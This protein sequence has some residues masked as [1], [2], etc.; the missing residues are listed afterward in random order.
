ME[1]DFLHYIWKFKLFNQQGLTTTDGEKLDLLKVGVHNHDA[2]P[3]FFNGQIRLAGTR[4]AGN[5]ELHLKSSDWFRHQHQ[6]DKAYDKVILHVVWEADKVVKRKNG[7]LIPTL[8]LKG[9]VSKSKLEQYQNLTNGKDWVPCQS[10]LNNLDPSLK[11]LQVERM[12]VERLEVKSRRINQIL[13]LHQNDWEQ[14][15][16]HLLCKYF[17]FKVNATPFELLATSLPFKIIRKNQTDLFQI[18]ALL[19]G[20]AGLLNQD[21][22]G[23]YPKKL[24]AAYEFQRKK[25]QLK[26]MEGHLWKFSRMR[27]SNFPTIRIAQLAKLLSQSE[28]LF[29]KV[30]NAEQL[31]QLEALFSLEA[32]PYWEAHYRLDVPAA[33]KQKKKLGKAS[34]HLLLINVVCPIMFTYGIKTDNQKMK[35]K[36]VDLLEKLPAEKNKLVR[37]WLEI[38]LS[39][40][41]AGDSQGMIQLKKEYCELKKCL[42]CMLGN[43]LITQA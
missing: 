37:K 10:Q 33:R 5:V 36:A 40:R 31:E 43:A 4:W 38:G 12:L 27:P 34:I 16:Y 11:A 30:I 24:K 15:F 7:E 22:K 17:G 26:A 35:D 25:Y 3:D 42:N 39:A 2:G 23:S 41:H 6:T 13:E 1:E 8:E 19:L 29:Q 28:N 9:R 14:A 18:E 21:F 20:Q 32:S